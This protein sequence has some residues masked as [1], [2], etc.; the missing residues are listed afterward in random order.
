MCVEGSWPDGSELKDKPEVVAMAEHGGEIFLT[1][2]QEP[3]LSTSAIVERLEAAGTYNA[4]QKLQELLRTEFK[5]NLDKNG[6]L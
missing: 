1:P 4:V 3:N 6:A 5:S 2:R